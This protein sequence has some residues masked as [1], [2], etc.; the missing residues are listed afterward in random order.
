MVNS[1]P[2]QL[3]SPQEFSSQLH[4]F[5]ECLDNHYLGTEVMVKISEF[6]VNNKD[7][8]FANP[9]SPILLNTLEL[10][11]RTRNEKDPL[12]E[13][14]QE[15]LLQLVPSVR[16]QFKVSL[17]FFRTSIPSFSKRIQSIAEWISLKK[18][19]LTYLDLYEE[20]LAGLLQE[21]EHIDLTNYHFESHDLNL[22]T[23]F[24]L[25][26]HLK[27]KTNDTVVLRTIA[28]ICA[29]QDPA[30]T[31]EFIHH[32]GIS[33][34]LVRADIA[35]MCAA[36][37]GLKTAQYLE[38]FNILPLHDQIASLCAK[39]D[40]RMAQFIEKFH[41]ACRFKRARIARHCAKQNGGFTAQFINNFDLD[42]ED[43]PEIARLC[44]KQDGEGTAKYFR[45]FDILNPRMRTEIARLCAQ[46][47]GGGTAEHIKNFEI[48]DILVL[49]LIAQDCAEQDGG[50][51]AKY[52]T[53]FGNLN[54]YDKGRLAVLCAKQNGPYT[55]YYI[56]NFCISDPAVE[57]E[58]FYECVMSNPISLFYTS[59]FS[60]R[61]DEFERLSYM[62]DV[63]KSN[64]PEEHIRKILFFEIDQLIKKLPE[65]YQEALMKISQEAFV[66]PPHTQNPMALWLLAS[67]LTMK[68]LTLDTI[69]W[70]F[71]QEIWSELALLRD[72]QLRVMLSRGLYELSACRLSRETWEPFLS[73]MSTRKGGQRGL[74]LLVIPLRSLQKKGVE[75]ELLVKFASALEYYQKQNNTQLRSV[76]P[77]RNIVHTL[78]AVASSD[79]Y[80]VQKKSAAV[81]II[82]WGGE[83][84]ILKN[85][86]TVK[87]LLQLKDLEWPTAGV[88]IHS[89]FRNSLKK[90]IP[91]ENCQGIESDKFQEIFG[92][93]RHPDGL[94]T[95]AAGLKSLEELQ[96][97]KCLGMYLGNVLEGTFKEKRYETKR[98][99]HLFKI[100]NYNPELLKLWKE[101]LCFDFEALDPSTRID[102]SPVEWLKKALIT[103]RHLG[104][105][106]L[107]FVSQYLEKDSD[108]NALFQKLIA[109]LKHTLKEEENT[110][111]R[112]KIKEFKKNSETLEGET[113]RIAEQEQAAHKIA[114]KRLVEEV[115]QDPVFTQLNLEKTCLNFVQKGQGAGK[116]SLI[117]LLEEIHNALQQHFATS[118]FA[119]DVKSLIETFK[120][121]AK[122]RG[123]EKDL[124]VIFTDDPIDLL[125]CGTEV[126]DSCQMLDGNLTAI[127]V[128]WA[129]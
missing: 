48:K 83:V 42:P 37:N 74:M 4:G 1:I 23:K 10:R 120:E 53:N 124:K 15:H 128:Y 19:P 2:S 108:K 51:T 31:A 32:F 55:A 33:D 127:K 82:H 106:T 107:P 66:L 52:F 30:C 7:L 71:H 49:Y 114:L 115:S 77:I 73:S 81:K 109:Q 12:I 112:K 39:Q 34:I 25:Q 56:S 65:K 38:N 95:Y 62:I 102:F 88:C 113:L 24:L 89:L 67:V 61:P 57:L 119:K 118:E 123:P 13:R 90:V 111:L 45:N 69:E 78:Q 26:S 101:D 43:M 129:I 121:E 68:R 46:Q 63:F 35:R 17:E 40:G 29:N 79:A 75:K 9:R 58:V 76:Y 64:E 41:I 20:E 104:E 6:F 18:I 59:R 72:P 16:E 47:N 103:D 97:M 3:L 21:L 92:S 125:L 22:F 105:L 50:G 36:Q 100:V 91:M 8:L 84:E 126:N 96:V 116:N 93:C 14:V 70:I 60:F 86:M 94:L 85:I 28:R 27:F 5:S 117:G 99:P 87:G 44:A 80:S 98:N 122:S 54:P 110:E 11:V